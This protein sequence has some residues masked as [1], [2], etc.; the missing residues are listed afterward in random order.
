VPEGHTLELASRRLRPLVGATVRD[1]PLGGATVIAVEARGKH[2]LVHADDGRSLHAHLGMHGGVRLVAP[3]QGRGRHVL[4]TEAGDA[5]IRGML[6]RVV[7]TARLRLALG[8]DAL[9]EPDQ[10]EF[11]R[12]V[13]LVDRA[14]G[15]AVM[16][17]RVIAGIGNIVK[18]EALWECRI[19]PFAAVADLDDV[20]LAELA[21]IAARILGEGVAAGGRLPGRVYR[22]A[23]RPCPRCQTAIRSSPQ[24]EQ[25]R[26]SYWCPA[27]CE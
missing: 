8:P 14:I 27:C 13:R 10:R 6:V 18:S 24:G 1:G 9:H 15:E 23:G 25:R 21:L 12:R 26:T 5:V 17:Q 2:L 20:R 22:R 7:T 4:R 3:G 19:D 11:L 16:D